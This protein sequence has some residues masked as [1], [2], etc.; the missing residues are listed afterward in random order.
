MTF[1]TCSMGSVAV[2]SGLEPLRAAV[3]EAL[4]G[5]AGETVCDT[6]PTCIYVD[7]PPGWALTQAPRFRRHASLVISD[8]PCPEY[9]LALL[10]ARPAGLIEN[11]QLGDIAQA[12][13]CIRAGER[14]RPEVASLLSP[15]ERRTLRL[16]AQG[17]ALKTI[18]RRRGVS[19]GTLRNTVSAIYGKL[20]LKS[21]AQLVLYFYGNW[22]TLRV[23]HGWQPPRPVTHTYDS[24]D[25][26]PLT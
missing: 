11:A 1:Y 8:N 2:V 3:A 26:T 5:F 12:L 6:A 13:A 17:Y 14:L 4:K 9:R 16:I 24:P 10:T 7:G 20:G 22:H 19:E 18:M 23:Y 15:S 21:H 25:M